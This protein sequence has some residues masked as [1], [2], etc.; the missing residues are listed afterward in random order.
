MSIARIFNIQR[1]SIHDGD[2]IRTT[3]F[4]K[5]C[6]LSCYWCHNPESISNKKELLY[7]DNKCSLCGKCVEECPSKALRI[8]DFKLFRSDD[9]SFCNRCVVYCS[10]QIREIVGSDISI[11]ELLK[12]VKKDI[13]FYEESSGGV[14]FSGG[15]P[16][17]QIDFI[18]QF[19]TLLK[20]EK[21]S[22]AVDTSGAVPF[23]YFERIAPN[24]DT[25]LYDIKHT[26]TE[27][28]KQFTGVEN[29]QIL[30]NLISLSY[31]HKN[32]YIRMPIIEGFNS[33]IEHINSVITLLK[34]T[35]IKKIFL[36]PYHN[37]A[38][39]KYSKLNKEFHDENFSVPTQ[40]KLNLFSE[41]F[42][43]NGFEVKIGG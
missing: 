9:C 24:V 38:Y 14:T 25:F 41:M 21:I 31:I 40:E 20:K 33:S 4:F 27:L 10:N 18:E 34:N 5:G 17:L 13:V 29:T 26:N 12:E 16:M 15:E 30:S 36:L 35:T 39:H 2:G 11:E 23:S 8:T 1:F 19:A 37:I 7:D 43:E 3:I 28:H 22:V 42:I 6:P 32:I